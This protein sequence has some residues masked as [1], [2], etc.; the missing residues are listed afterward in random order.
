MAT[1]SGKHFEAQV[2]TSILKIENIYYLRLSDPPQAF[3][4]SSLTK[5]SNNNPFD[6]IMYKYPLLYA[7]ENKTTIGTSFSF[8]LDKNDKN[9]LIHAHQII[10]LWDAYQSGLFTGFLFNFRD[11]E[12]TYFIHIYD[13]MQY[14]K[15]T[16]KKSI[17]ESD[18]IKY[19]GLLI[20]QQK[21][22]TNYDYD[23]NTLLKYGEDNFGK[24][25]ELRFNNTTN[26]EL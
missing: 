17:N 11:K 3:S 26:K 15:F 24:Y 18:I 9:T 5:F 1:N 12:N 4:Q 10:G 16:T 21:K 2:R 7:I 23:I 14:V 22:R 8:S 6:F 20:P 19:S 25:K 13:F